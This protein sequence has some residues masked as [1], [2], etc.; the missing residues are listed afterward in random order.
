MPDEGL[1]AI[2]HLSKTYRPATHAL[3]DVSFTLD[4]GCTL[5]V[6]GASG[7]G[8]S[9]LARCLAG[10]ERPTSGEIH[11][12]GT[13]QLIFQ[14]PA[15]S[16]NPRFTAAEIVEEPLLIQRRPDRRARAMAAIEQVGLSAGDVEKPS[17]YFSGGEKQRLAIARALVMDAKLIILDESLTGLDPNLQSQIVALLRDLQSRLGLAYIMISHDLA[18]AA[19]L[20]TDI[21]VM[22]EGQM[23]EH[24]AAS[25]IL[26][27]PQHPITRDLIAAAKALA[28]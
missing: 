27:R 26:T 22:H 24:G 3:R 6:V 25:E 23:V 15:A 21:G 18:L 1:L 10:F 17:R 13:I 28:V 9:T 12:H 20:A 4:A 8:K 5:A 11:V 19:E 16:L 7:S 14:Q 2:R